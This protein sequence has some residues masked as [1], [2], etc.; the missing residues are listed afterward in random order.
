MMKKTV[1]SVEEAIGAL[2]NNPKIRSVEE[3]TTRVLVQVSD[4]QSDTSVRARV[5]T[6]RSAVRELGADPLTN[7]GQRARKRNSYNYFL[8]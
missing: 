4:V 1:T 3:L 7:S 2:Q 5:R 8:L 6:A